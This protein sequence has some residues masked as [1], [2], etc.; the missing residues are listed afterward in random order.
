MR[1]D[2]GK[3]CVAVEKFSEAGLEKFLGKKF[4]EEE[5]RNELSFVMHEGTKFIAA[6]AKIEL[7]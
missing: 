2:A 4:G 7:R 3:S 6:D 5:S 1:N